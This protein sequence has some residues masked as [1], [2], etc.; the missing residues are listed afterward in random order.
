MRFPALLAL[1]EVT[2]KR[3]QAVSLHTALCSTECCNWHKAVLL[4]KRRPPFCCYSARGGGTL[5]RMSR[6]CAAACRR[7]WVA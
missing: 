3:E 7:R 5:N 4:N 1:L 6:G 2:T